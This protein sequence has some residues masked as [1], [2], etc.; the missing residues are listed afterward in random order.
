MRGTLNNAAGDLCIVVRPYG[1]CRFGRDRFDR[2]HERVLIGENP[3][4]ESMRMQLTQRFGHL[5]RRHGAHPRLRKGAIEAEIDLRNARDCSEALL[6]VRAIDAES[7][8]VVERPGL[9]TEEI[10]ALDEL[11]VFG[12]VRDLD[13]RRF[14]KPR[15]HRFDH[16]HARDELTMLL[17]RDI[18]GDKDAEMSDRVVQR[19]NDGLAVGDNFIDV[20]VEVEYPVE[21]LLRRRDVVAP[22]TEAD[23]R[24]LDVS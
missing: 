24:R 18:A 12:L 15:R 6:V 3:E 4:P 8:N 22:G 1:G 7:A 17:Q 2:P 13:D 23:D 9:E 20:V 21:R 5:L 19:V 14:I 10:L 11:P 16:L